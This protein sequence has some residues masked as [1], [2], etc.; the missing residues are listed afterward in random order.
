MK[1]VGLLEDGTEDWDAFDDSD[2]TQRHIHRNNASQKQT[3][4]QT[5]PTA[6]QIDTFGPMMAAMYDTLLEIR[7][8]ARELA[9]QGSQQPSS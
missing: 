3:E 1:Y 6:N 9:K 8:I 2:F 4:S 5:I 7:D